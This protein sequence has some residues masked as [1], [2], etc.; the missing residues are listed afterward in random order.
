V[1]AEWAWDHF[2]RVHD[3]NATEVSV[4]FLREVLAESSDAATV[5]FDVAAVVD[6]VPPPLR[7]TPLAAH[8]PPSSLRPCLT[9]GRALAA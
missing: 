5:A 8:A 7:A 6:P 9:V 2:L 3:T 1:D 4:P